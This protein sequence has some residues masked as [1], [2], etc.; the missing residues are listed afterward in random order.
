MMAAVARDMVLANTYGS[1]SL[2]IVFL[3]G[4]FIIPKGRQHH[5]LYIKEKIND[6]VISGVILLLFLQQ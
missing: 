4:G 1:A 6:I 2:L 3:L 5:K